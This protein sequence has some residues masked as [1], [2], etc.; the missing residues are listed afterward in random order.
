MRS[1]FTH[2]L[3]EIFNIVV[4]VLLF[5][6]LFHRDDRGGGS[7]QPA[8]RRPQLGSQSLHSRLLTLR[9]SLHSTVAQRQSRCHQ[10]RCVCISYCPHIASSTLVTKR[11]CF[12]LAGNYTLD[13][14]LTVLLTTGMF[15]GGVTG[16]ILDNTIAGVC[17]C[18]LT[19]PVL[20]AYIM[21]S[22]LLV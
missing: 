13:S 4:P 2:L 5:F 22:L 18:S 12:S 1:L 19:C 7:L 3:R 6:T 8:E 21:T 14:I 20:T 11:E 10:H 15:V 16:F 9:R 17:V